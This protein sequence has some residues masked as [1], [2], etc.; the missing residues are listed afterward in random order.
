MVIITHNQAKE[1][2]VDEFEGFF[3]APSCLLLKPHSII[4]VSH[5]LEKCTATVS[6]GLNERRVMVVRGTQRGD[7]KHFG[8]GWKLASQ[9]SLGVEV[10]ARQML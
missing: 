10:R 5:N 8:H 7:L 2:L 4:Y 9:D 3:Q 1:R 6:V